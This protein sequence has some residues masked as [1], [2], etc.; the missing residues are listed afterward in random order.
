MDPVRAR[1]VPEGVGLRWTIGDVSP[2]GFEALRLA[3]WG[4]WKLFGPRSR[5]VVCV[6]SISVD[7]AKQ[8][9]G[10]VPEGVEWLDNTQLAPKWLAAHV[11][12]GM[13]EGVIWKMAP[14]RLFPDLREISFDNDVVLWSIPSAMKQWLACKEE[15]TCLM[16]ED[17][18]RALGQFSPLCDERPINSGIRGVP[19]GF[20]LEGRIENLLART[21]IVLRSE[22]D[23]QGLQAAVL[24]QGQLNLV[25]TDDVTICSPFPNH[26]QHFGRCGAH[27]V[28]LNQR[29]MPWTLEGRGAHV[30]IAERWQEQR[31]I[32]EA[33]VLER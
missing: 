20:D 32:V 10:A 2:Q 14:V 27:F 24:S 15:S 31:S 29:C 19:P 4:A 33:L 16:A 9:S 23:E 7:W 26:Q 22:L 25:S 30:V 12:E 21:K 17:V 8:Q 3:L 6:N 1:N 5:Y 28:G 18:G 13:A 11:D